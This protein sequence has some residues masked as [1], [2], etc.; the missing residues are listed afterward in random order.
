MPC[1][2]FILHICGQT[3]V[4]ITIL[5]SIKGG[6]SPKLSLEL[7]VRN[8]AHIVITSSLQLSEDAHETFT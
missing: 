1:N 3:T 6:I 8:H 5:V 2:K 7:E 4:Q